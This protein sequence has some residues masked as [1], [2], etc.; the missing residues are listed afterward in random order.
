LCGIAAYEMTCGANFFAMNSTDIFEAIVSE[1]YEALYRFA[2]TLTRAESDAC[3]LTQHTFYVWATKGQQMRDP[4]KVKSWLF[5][6]LYRAFLAVKRKQDRFPHLV[7]TPDDAEEMPAES[8]DPSRQADAGQV[9]PALAKV[10][11]VFQAALAL[12]YLN[13]YSYKEIA[14]ILEVPVGTVKSR[15]ARGIIQLR[16]IL[17]GDPLKWDLSAALSVEPIGA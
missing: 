14:A 10:D 13:D 2:L 8:P 17:N 16:E 5:T 12:Y 4:A 3:D 6:T 11:E 1:H 15:I 7:L 9:L